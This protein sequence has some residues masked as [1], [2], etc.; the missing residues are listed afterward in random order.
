MTPLTKGEV[1]R[2]L[3]HGESMCLLDSIDTWDALTITCRTSTHRD[4]GNPLRFG[5]RLTAAAGLEY[6]AQAMGAHVGLVDGH[7]KN[8]Q[9]VGLVGSVR[10]VVFAADRLDD[11]EGPLIVSAKRLIEGDQG[12]IYEF[13]VAHGAATVIAG[14]ASIFLR[15]AA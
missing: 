6:A 11:F 7:G 8:Q 4:E 12:Y 9:P 5:G 2:L 15:T 14:R 1:R 13:T 10:E 3:P